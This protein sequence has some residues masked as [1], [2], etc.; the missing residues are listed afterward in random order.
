MFPSHWNP[1]EAPIALWGSE[2]EVEKRGVLF[3]SDPIIRVLK[4]RSPVYAATEM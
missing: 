4:V 2:N 3:L 1:V